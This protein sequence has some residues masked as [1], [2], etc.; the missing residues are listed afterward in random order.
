[1]E[2]GDRKNLYSVSPSEM[3]HDIFK[4]KR[5]MMFL[6]KIGVKGTADKILYAYILNVKFSYAF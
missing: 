6:E 5:I 3:Y 4:I 2:I 1:M